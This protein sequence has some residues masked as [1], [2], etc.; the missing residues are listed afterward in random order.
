M[1]PITINPHSMM[2]TNDMLHDNVGC[3]VWAECDGVVV[4]S[5]IADYAETKQMSS[6]WAEKGILLL[7]DQ[8]GML[9]DD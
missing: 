7:N 4:T 3:S 8:I 9:L 5:I 1:H 6:E 2:R